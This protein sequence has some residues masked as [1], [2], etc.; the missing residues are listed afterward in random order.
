MP[1][2]LIIRLAWSAALIFGGLTLYALVRRAILQRSR[3]KRAGLGE[4]LPGVPAILYFTTP[5]CAPCKTIQRPALQQVHEQLGGKLQIIEV[6]ATLQ[7]DM[8]SAWHVLSV[9]TTFVIDTHGQ[10]RHV[11]FGATGAD[12]LLRQIAEAN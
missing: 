4:L 1:V 12:K 11:N 3:K 10:P 6:D 2:G 7:P 8:A 5:D 9:P